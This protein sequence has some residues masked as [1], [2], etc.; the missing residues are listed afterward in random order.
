[1]EMNEFIRIQREKRNRTMQRIRQAEAERAARMANVSE[2][3][4]ESNALFMTAI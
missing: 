4:M 1:M 2:D 3:H